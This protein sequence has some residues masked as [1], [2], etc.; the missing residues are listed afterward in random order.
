MKLC[1]HFRTL[2]GESGTYAAASPDSNRLA[3]RVLRVYRG[4]H[5]SERF[6]LGPPATWGLAGFLWRVPPKITGIATFVTLPGALG[7]SYVAVW[8]RFMGHDQSGF[9]DLM[10][11]A[12]CAG[13][14]LDDATTNGSFATV[15]KTVNQGKLVYTRLLEYQRTIRMT[16]AEASALQTALDLL[17]SRLKFFGEKF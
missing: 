15:L 8:R 13:I 12:Q 2:L 6:H 11:E 4:R 1:W 14:A 3:S 16:K 17:R 10:I 9:N 5:Q 7:E